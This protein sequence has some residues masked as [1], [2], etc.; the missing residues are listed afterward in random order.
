MARTGSLRATS[1]RT[2]SPPVYPLAPMTTTG[3]IA[4]VAGLAPTSE[5][6]KAA[7]TIAF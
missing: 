5:F 4:D 2:Q 6:A 3:A 1:S 7:E